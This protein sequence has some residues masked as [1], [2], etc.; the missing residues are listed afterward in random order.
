MKKLLGTFL[1]LSLFGLTYGISFGATFSQTVKTATTTIRNSS[2]EQ[3]L[4]SGLS[5]EVSSLT[6]NYT[7]QIVS[8][9][10]LIY[11]YEYDLYDY[12]D[13]PLTFTASSSVGVASS[14]MGQIGTMTATNSQFPDLEFH[15]DKYY[16]VIF[17]NGNFNAY[18]LGSTVDYYANGTSTGAYPLADLSFT[19]TTSASAG[20][21][22]SSTFPINAVVS[23]NQ[24][25]FQGQFYNE[26]AYDRIF[27]TL[28]YEGNNNDQIPD[29]TRN[30]TGT[31]PLVSGYANFSKTLTLED[32]YYFYT[33]GLYNSETGELSTLSDAY[34]FQVIQAE[35]GTVNFFDTDYF[36]TGSTTQTDVDTFLADLGYEL[37]ST[38]GSYL[39]PETWLNI[40]YNSVLRFMGVLIKPSNYSYETFQ[41]S[42]AQFSTLFP[43][44]IFYGLNETTRNYLDQTVS[45]Q[46]ITVNNSILGN[47]T[48]VSDSLFTNFF[49]QTEIDRFRTF[50]GNLIWAGTIVKIITV[51]L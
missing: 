39:N 2:W 51:V 28:T 5:G 38:S 42:L 29:W 33:V 22:A 32:G 41:Q 20:S 48:L 36:S 18:G 50:F 26:S 40:G 16:K 34:D 43:F 44:N 49:T 14:S 3:R 17:G 31:I 1:G 12:S 35:S 15:W 7:D 6:F 13:N 10:D 21:S 45:T 23:S 47:I 8:T 37:A 25:Q 46:N 19:L 30:Y 9:S 11:F 4:G 27:I 24:V